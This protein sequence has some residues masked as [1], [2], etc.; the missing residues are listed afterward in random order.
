MMVVAVMVVVVGAGGGWGGTR[1]A[2]LSIPLELHVHFWGYANFKIAGTVRSRWAR[3]GVLIS[4]I[5]VALR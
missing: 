4:C 2:N 5:A 3:E 1:G